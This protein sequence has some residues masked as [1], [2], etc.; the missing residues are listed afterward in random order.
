MANRPEVTKIGLQ[1]AALLALSAVL[2]AI[3]K[4]AQLPAALLLGPMVAAIAVSAA[5]ATVRVP[6]GPY[7]AAQA[8]L[9]CLIARS[10]PFSAFGELLRDWPL[11]LAGILSVIAASNSLGWLLTRWRVLPGTAAIWGSSPGAAMA[12]TLMAEAYGADVRLV[13]FMQYLR[14][15]CVVLV[16]SVVARVWGVA[17]GVVIAE[18]VWFPAVAWGPLAGTLA[19]AGAGIFAARR[20]RVPAGAMLVPLA[21]GVVLQG[22]GWLAIELPPWLLAAS[23]ALIGWSIGLRFTR[24][25]LRHAARALI[26]VVASIMTL[27]AVCALFALALVQIAGIDPLTAYLATSPGGADSV[28]IIAAN[29]PVNLPFVV[30]MQTARFLLVLL[31]G[32]SLAR[33]IAGK[34]TAAAKRRDPQSH[35]DRSE[36][37]G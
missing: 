35:P 2:V 25:I 7:V 4:V 28:A 26:P 31:T 13:A 36:I 27:L 34:A 14:V 8:V 17:S 11:L 22:G 16:A 32:P 6:A 20:L 33:F 15:A 1:W 5:G 18:P 21:F 10:L 30:A 24:P 3:L 19:L 37:D 23:Y 9:G 29:S 12:M